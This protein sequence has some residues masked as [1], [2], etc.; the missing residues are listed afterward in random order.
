M[1]K[2]LSPPTITD[3]SLANLEIQRQL[4][5]LRVSSRK[6]DQTT[7]VTRANTEELLDLKVL[8][9]QP[10]AKNL[11]L[12][13]RLASTLAAMSDSMTRL[14][15]MIES[16]AVRLMEMQENFSEKLTILERQ[17][18]RQSDLFDQLFEPED[19]DGS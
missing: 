2:P 14:E 9:D 7:C 10:D 16:Q 8:L 12:A 6:I 4:Q 15:A 18:N 17:M 11:E 5:E 13:E 3:P 1:N 19:G